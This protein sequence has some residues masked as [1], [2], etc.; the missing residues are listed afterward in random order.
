MGNRVFRDQITQ[1]FSKYELHEVGEDGD[2]VEIV[3]RKRMHEFGKGYR[4]T[5]QKVHLT[6]ELTRKDA[7]AIR[8]L[9]DHWLG[10]SE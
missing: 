4:E 8:D 6:H 7:R 10:E 2:N 3:K 5:G 1:G 9:L